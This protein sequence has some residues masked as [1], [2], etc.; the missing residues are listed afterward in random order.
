[1]T[2]QEYGHDKGL[3]ERNSTKYGSLLATD[4][5]YTHLPQRLLAE[6]P[7]DLGGQINT[8]GPLLGD[9]STWLWGD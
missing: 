4:D 5:E 8:D 2:L 3:G 7:A 9:R 1:M 6:K